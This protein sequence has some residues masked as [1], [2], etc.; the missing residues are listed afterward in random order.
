MRSTLIRLCI[1][2]LLCLAACGK[3]QATSCRNKD[4]EGASYIVC[5]FNPAKEELRTF[6]RSDNRKPYRTF[7]ALA[8]DWFDQFLCSC[9]KRRHVNVEVT[10]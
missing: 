7:A 9:P 3:A 4:F 2:I 6:W 10:A 8:A 1:A 5:S